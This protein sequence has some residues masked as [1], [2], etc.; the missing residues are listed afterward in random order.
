MPVAYVDQ[1]FALAIA[2]YDPLQDI[3]DGRHAPM[4]PL[5]VLPFVI[6]VVILIVILVVTLELALAED[7]VLMLPVVASLPSPLSLGGRPGDGNQEHE[8][9]ND[10][11][12][13]G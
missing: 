11:E 3:G 8:G 12:D 9:E 1:R 4:M 13:V 7:A 5:A 2:E 6:V 10:A